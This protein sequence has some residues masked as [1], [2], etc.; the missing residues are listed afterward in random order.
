MGCDLVIHGM[1]VSMFV[2]CWIIVDDS[3]SDCW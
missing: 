1:Y 3:G 2:G